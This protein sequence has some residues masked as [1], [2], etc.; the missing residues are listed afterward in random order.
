MLSLRLH[1]SDHYISIFKQI[2]IQLAIFHA[3]LSELL[4]HW[5]FFMHLW[6]LTFAFNMLGG[7]FFTFF[8]HYKDSWKMQTKLQILAL[9]QLLQRILQMDFRSSHLLFRPCPYKQT[10][11]RQQRQRFDCF[12]GRSRILCHYLLH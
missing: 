10:T 4:Y 5:R 12:S 7:S 8:N 3:F 11:S 6:L 2:R 1:F 9:L